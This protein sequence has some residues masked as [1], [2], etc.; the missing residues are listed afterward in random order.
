MNEGR[1]VGRQEE[2]QNRR[3]EIE[4]NK[5][6][7][8]MEK[9]K[10]GW[11]EGRKNLGLGEGLRVV[12]HETTE[13]PTQ[14]GFEH[15]VRP[16]RVVEGPVQVDEEGAVEGGRHDQVPQLLEN[17]FLVPL[18]GDLALGDHLD[19]KHFLFFLVGGKVDLCEE[20]GWAGEWGNSQM[21][22]VFFLG[23]GYY[24]WSLTYI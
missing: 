2:H 11:K 5:R 20:E 9:R 15:Q 10:D 18:L 4:K 24:G 12:A 23:R 6:S 21:K 22:G 14:D 1:K 19:G 8:D 7:K 13:G 17:G 3:K 16:K